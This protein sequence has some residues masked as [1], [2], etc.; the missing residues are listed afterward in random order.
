MTDG[1]LSTKQAELETLSLFLYRRPMHP[2]LFEIYDDITICREGIYEARIWTTGCSHVINFYSGDMTLCEVVADDVSKL[3]KQ[4]LV[5]SLPFKKETKFKTQFPPEALYTVNTQTEK[6][7]K[8][9]YEDTQSDLLRLG[10]KK[11]GLVRFPEWRHGNLEPFTYISTEAR[12]SRLHTMSFHAFPANRTITK[13]Q[14][15]F[16]LTPEDAG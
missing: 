1:H 6:M 13:V 10:R 8:R 14:S 5:K 12:P 7:T 15:I 3:P 2:E 9:V 11:G 4:G 16:Q